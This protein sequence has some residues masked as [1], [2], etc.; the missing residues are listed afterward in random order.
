MTNWIKAVNPLSTASTEPEALAAARASAIA[1]FIGVIYGVC[2]LVFGMN[3]MKAGI[4]AQPSTGASPEMMFQIAM[5][6]AAGVVIIQLVLGLVQWF[7]PNMAIPIIFVILVGYGLVSI[8]LGRMMAANMG[9][10]SPAVPAWQMMLSVVVML[11]ELALHI[12]GIRGASALKRFRDARA[13]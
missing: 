10:E 4:E 2:G 11:V 3:M 9:I 6:L 13:Y 7:K 1:I 12:A 5:G 8:P